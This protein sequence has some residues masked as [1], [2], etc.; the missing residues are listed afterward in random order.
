MTGKEVH[1]RVSWRSGFFSQIFLGDPGEEWIAAKPK[2]RSDDDDDGGGEYETP[3]IPSI[4]RELLDHPAARFVTSLRV[5]MPN[6]G[7]EG[8]A[9]FGE[10]IKVLAKHAA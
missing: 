4:L 5:G 7:D 3:E 10:V 9:D 6:P 1:M 8:N 2:G